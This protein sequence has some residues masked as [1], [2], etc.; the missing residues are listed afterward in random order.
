MEKLWDIYGMLTNSHILSH[1]LMTLSAP[2]LPPCSRHPLANSTCLWISVG[3]AL[4]ILSR[5]ERLARFCTLG[6]GLERPNRDDS[7]IVLVLGEVMLRRDMDESTE[8]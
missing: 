1:L 4:A 3:F 5:I 8:K 2:T 6:T 7:D